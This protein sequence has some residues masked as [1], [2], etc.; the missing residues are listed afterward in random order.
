VF[1]LLHAVAFGVVLLAL[2]TNP[3]PLVLYLTPAF[4][5]FARSR[6]FIFAYF[7]SF[8]VSFRCIPGLPSVPRPVLVRG[9]FLVGRF[10]LASCGFQ[11]RFGPLFGYLRRDKVVEIQ[12]HLSPR[13]YW[14]ITSPV[15]LLTS[16]FLASF[17]NPVLGV[18]L[19]AASHELPKAD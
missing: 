12:N 14:Q 17:I 15:I 1:Y 7:L 9:L 18:S 19:E 4:R 16:K 5:V 8:G 10:A 11:Y 2:K 13:M 3:L 6:L